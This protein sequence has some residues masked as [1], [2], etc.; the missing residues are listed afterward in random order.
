MLEFLRLFVHVL[1][2]RFR[3][4]AQLEAEI[5]VLRHQLSVLQR[6]T[7][8]RPIGRVRATVTGLRLHR[9]ENS[10]AGPARSDAKR[11]SAPNPCSLHRLLQRT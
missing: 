6:Q 2:A 1:V 3:T 9:N 11:V 7:A 5:T 8:M 4:Q 10:Q